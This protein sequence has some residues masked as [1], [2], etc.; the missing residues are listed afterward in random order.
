MEK[1]KPV[2]YLICFLLMLIGT[3]FS[4]GQGINFSGK[5]KFNASK[6]KQNEQFSMAPL[7]VTITQ[8]GNSMTLERHYNFQGQD[9][10]ST[11][12]YTL[13]G[14]EC[15]NQ[16]WQGSQKKSTVSWTEDNKSL[17]LKSKVPMQDGGEFSITETISMAG[18]NLSLAV[19]ATSPMGELVETYVF[20]KQ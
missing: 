11:D 5:W 18:E 6:S 9:F 4:Y 19:N 20:D 8:D 12:K 13:D 7:D 15:V 14:K 10:T 2:F 3:G 17:V 16:G 1:P